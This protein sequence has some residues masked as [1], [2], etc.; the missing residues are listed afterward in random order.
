MTSSN[1]PR[2]KSLLLIIAPAL[3]SAAAFAQTSAY[4]TLIQK[5]NAQLQAGNATQAESIG[6]QAIKS[7][8]N[9]WQAYALTGGA[10][11]NLK[12]YND[13][14]TQLSKALAFAP[15]AKQPAIQ[16]LIQQCALAGSTPT[17]HPVTPAAQTP[18]Q[19]AV[20]QAEVVLWESIQNSQ[21]ANDFQVYL[22]Q[23]PNGAYA[24]LAQS[25]LDALNAQ[26]A[27]AA[28]QLNS[29]RFFDTKTNLDWDLTAGPVMSWSSAAS[30]CQAVKLTGFDAPNSTWRLA[31]YDELYNVWTNS[32]NAYQPI[33]S[34]SDSQTP[35]QMWTSTPG[36]KKKTHVIFSKSIVTQ[37]DQDD[38]GQ[39]YAVCVRNST[40]N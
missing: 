14:I 40:G 22:Q 12:R 31:T 17:A 29:I 30:Y 27:A 18:P 3:L 21:N 28:A 34:G 26:V 36:S 33:I 11:M 38:S 8:P 9:G 35:V 20:T 10:L 19:P 16:S 23:Y 25:R 13:A 39:S 24:A 6:E 2:T 7:N 15:A 4:D 32:N 37:W 1:H 5:G